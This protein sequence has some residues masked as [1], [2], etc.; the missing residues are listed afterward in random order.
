MVLNQDDEGI[1]RKINAFKNMIELEDNPQR[2]RSG[3]YGISVIAIAL[4]QKKFF[5][6][7]NKMIP[8]VL[9]ALNDK[10][11]KVQ[12]AACDAIYNM[13]KICNQAI[14]NSDQFLSIFKTVINLSNYPNPEVKEYSRKVDELLKDV[15]SRSLQKSVNFELDSLLE[16]IC[17]ML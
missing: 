4:Y 7:I 5:S 2:R 6:Y 3:L 11:V 9:N 10:D 1:K 8:P 15:V 14:L 17:Q 13:I 16:T 12:H